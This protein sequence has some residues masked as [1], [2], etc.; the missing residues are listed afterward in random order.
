MVEGTRARRRDKLKY[1]DGIK[2]W[3]DAELRVKLSAQLK[4]EE[5]GAPLSATSPQK[6]LHHDK[7]KL[8]ELASH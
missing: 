7:V 2:N 4:R 8:K 3:W 6:T 1:T 5:D